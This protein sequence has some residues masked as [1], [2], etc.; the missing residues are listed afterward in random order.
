M[1]VGLTLSCPGFCCTVP[2]PLNVMVRLAFDASLVRTRLPL[3][4]PDV[5]VKMTLKV[6][7]CAG[8]RINGRSR[9]VALKSLPVNVACVMVRL[10]PPVLVS[11]SV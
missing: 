11:V 10:L 1:V 7:L 4:L 2:D 6:A 9:P 5:G 8:A 3:A